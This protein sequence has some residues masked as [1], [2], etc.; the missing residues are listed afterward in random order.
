MKTYSVYVLRKK[1]RRRGIHGSFVVPCRTA[2]VGYAD[3]LAS[4]L[5]MATGVQSVFKAPAFI[6]DF[7][8]PRPTL[9]GW[10]S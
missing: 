7:S 6:A 10:Q 3:S 4:A 5:S 8:K 9:E 1:S 2:I